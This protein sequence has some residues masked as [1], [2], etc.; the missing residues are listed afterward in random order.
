MDQVRNIALAI[1]QQRFW[2]LSCIS[3]IAAVVCWN[4]ATADLAKR[5]ATRKGTIEGAFGQVSS[6]TSESFHPNDAVIQGNQAQVEEQKKIVGQLW[7]DLYEHQRSEVLSWPELGDGFAVQMA[8]KK[9]ND[10]ISTIMRGRYRD[11]IQKQF[12]ALQDIVK[13]R[14]LEAMDNASSR[15]F[16]QEPQ[17]PS[18]VP[19][20]PKKDFLVDWLDQKMLKQRL[21]FPRMPSAL[22]IWVT[23]EDL[24]VY[25]NL[26]NI[27]AKTNQLH[28]ASRQDNTAISSIVKLQVGK[29][30]STDL[31]T[32]K[33]IYIPTAP[34]DAFAVGEPGVGAEVP[35]EPTELEA[36]TIIL[37]N[38]YL[39]E[40][41]VPYAGTAGSFGTE[42]RKLPIRMVLRMDQR[43]L[44]VVLVECANAPLPIE[45][46]QI[47]V[48]AQKS[49]ST[50]FS[51]VSGSS[52]RAYRR[53]P[54]RSNN[55]DQGDT[56][57][58]SEVDIKGVVLIYEQPDESVMPA[59]EAPTS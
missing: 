3:L 21:D 56:R 4:S 2:V 41:G 55:A 48:N 59:E 10:P 26:L 54:T 42:Y 44:P 45:V 11:Y 22:Q 27:I 23:Q 1:W 16:E 58:L 34:G 40:Q 15:R 43:M 17:D 14:D 32:S 6:I 25:K 30:A 31:T 33:T 18:T 38:R 52:T 7:S 29:D 57:E 20:E 37:E 53:T 50:G 47:S 13:A 39:D 12:V 9:F 8:T 28:G 51:S 5:F 49:N 35:A 24:W 46:T 19:E 36:D